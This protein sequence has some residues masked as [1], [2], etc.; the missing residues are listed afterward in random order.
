MQRIPRLT[1]RSQHSPYSHADKTSTVHPKHHAAH[2]H[3][4]HLTLTTTKLT[5][6]QQTLHPNTIAHA[7]RMPVNRTVRVRTVVTTTHQYAN[8]L[9]TTT[10]RTDRRPRKRPPHRTQ[11]SRA[12]QIRSLAR[13]GSVRGNRP[14]TTKTPSLTLKLTTT[15]QNNHQTRT[16]ALRQQ[17]LVAHTKHV[18]HAA[19]ARRKTGTKTKHQ[20]RLV[21]DANHTITITPAN[22]RQSR[23]LAQLRR[24]H[25]TTHRRNRRPLGL[26]HQLTPRRPQDARHTLE[27]TREQTLAI[28]SQHQRT[29]KQQPLPNEIHLTKNKK[30]H[31][32]TD[33]KDTEND[34]HTGED[35]T[36]IGKQN[37]RRKTATDGHDKR[38]GE[39]TTVTIRHASDGVL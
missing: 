22:H 9:R 31:I 10:Q 34:S 5:H 4:T 23:T 19:H 37:N 35:I 3:T 32:Y 21:A 30:R 24:R 2:Q 26:G 13:A 33:I 15:Q 7:R 38:K 17:K 28:H 12:A 39:T 29:T 36:S 11:T 14:L 27:H 6:T 25:A 20:T 1:A 8:T 18:T 16:H